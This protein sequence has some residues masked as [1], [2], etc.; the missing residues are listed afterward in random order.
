MPQSPEDKQPV[1]TPWHQPMPQSNY[2]PQGTIAE[3]GE[4]A[5]STLS[6]LSPA[7]RSWIAGFIVVVAI[8]VLSDLYMSIK[9]MQ[10]IA[11]SD[12]IVAEYFQ[13][14]ETN[15]AAELRRSQETI[16]ALADTVAREAERTSRTTAQAVDRATTP[17]V[18]ER[19]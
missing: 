6:A 15:R 18:K 19:D 1:E 4:A 16:K 13:F 10:T 5:S 3:A 12:K 2:P 14:L 7:D 11:E 9:Q 17:V 8:I